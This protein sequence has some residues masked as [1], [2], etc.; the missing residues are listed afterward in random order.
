V[1]NDDLMAG[2][3]AD[4]LRVKDFHDRLRIPVSYFVVPFNRQTGQR[5][6]QDAELLD[7]M[8]AACAAGSEFHP[9]SY[10][11]NLFEWGYPEIVAAM[12]ISREACEAFADA[13]FAIDDYNRKDRMRER[14]KRVAEEW[15]RATGQV[16]RGFR[17]GWGSFSRTLYE[18]L[19][20][21]GFKWTSLR[22]ASRTP[23]MWCKDP[24]TA[25]PYPERINPAVGLVPFRQEGVIEFPL[26]GDFGFHTRR[27]NKPRLVE[28]FKRQF[29]QCAEAGAPCVLCHHPHALAAANADANSGYE[30]YADIFAWLR[31][32]RAARFVT[33]SELYE[34]WKHRAVSPQPQ[35]FP[36]M[37]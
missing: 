19:T 8:Q 26:L 30:I 24:E 2:K 34:E 31:E 28:L 15:H 11:H 32:N 16:P 5:I 18:V 21:E 7:A 29:G 13:R 22:F 17:S 14:M 37:G 20:E 12:E 4:L 6:S 23:W 33:M 1:T 3:S 36:Q 35:T 9:H 10:K 27:A 25:P